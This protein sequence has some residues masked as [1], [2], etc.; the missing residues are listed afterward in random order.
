MNE[1]FNSFT[2]L[3]HQ[4]QIFCC[5]VTLE[6]FIRWMVFLSKKNPKSVQKR[7]KGCAFSSE[8]LYQAWLSV[9]VYSLICWNLD[10]LE[11]TGEMS[12]RLQRN[13][14]F[15]PSAC[16]DIVSMCP[17][18]VLSSA[19]DEPRMAHTPLSLQSFSSWNKP[20]RIPKC[21]DR[22][23]QA[24]PYLCAMRGA[25]TESAGDQTLFHTRHRET[26]GR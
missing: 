10:K 6:K 7:K 11:S 15:T 17:A 5:S 3:K 12:R 1:L 23:R 26:A 24:L 8:L 25:G 22:H 13:K 14:M 18:P 20:H 4:S 21:C 16:S 9:G 2:D 19:P